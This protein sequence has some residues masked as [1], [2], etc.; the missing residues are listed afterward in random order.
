MAYSRIEPFGSE[1]DFYRSG[2]I[3]STLA[4]CYRDKKKKPNPFEPQDFMG[5]FFGNKKP[6]K[7]LK[8]PLRHIAKLMGAKEVKREE[9]DAQ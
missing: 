2:I 3:A 5:G 7:D 6:T 8:D 9:T 1:A 4:N